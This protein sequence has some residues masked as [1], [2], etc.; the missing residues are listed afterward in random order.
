MSQSTKIKLAAFEI[1]LAAILTAVWHFTFMAYCK[2][3]TFCLFLAIGVIAG[4]YDMMHY[5]EEYFTATPNKPRMKAKIIANVIIK[6]LVLHT[7]LY[8]S[9][10]FSAF[11]TIVEHP[12]YLIEFATYFIWF[13]LFT[14]VQVKLE[15]L[16]AMKIAKN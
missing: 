3:S 1:A 16:I 14:E 7:M 15:K 6:V 9:A 11:D 13:V 10:T 12:T 8:T 5:F 2:G 4:G